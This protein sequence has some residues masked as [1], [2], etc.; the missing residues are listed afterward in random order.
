MILVPP[1]LKASL[2]ATLS[3]PSDFVEYAMPDESRRLFLKGAAVAASS[4]ILPFNSYANDAP[5]PQSYAAPSLN[6]SEATI[7]EVSPEPELALGEIPLDFWDR[8]RELWLHRSSSK[9]T[10]KATYWKDGKL[11]EEGYLKICSILR[12]VKYK[13]STKI[14]VGLLDVLRGITGYYEAWRWPYPLVI[15]SGFRTIAHNK[16]LVSEGAA[17]NSMHLYGKAVDVYMPGIPIKDIANLAVY[18]KKGGVGFYP[19]KLFVHI[20]TGKI[21]RWNGR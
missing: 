3:L 1:H 14:D 9:E 17:K 18:F 5:A 4:L 8:P 19:S 12:D 10:V 13:S 16:S 2:P 20:D 7:S 6:S 11:D 15:N 21:R